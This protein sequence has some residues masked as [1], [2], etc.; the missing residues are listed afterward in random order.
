[1]KLKSM[2]LG[3]ALTTSLFLGGC[4]MYTVDALG[5]LDLG[6]SGMHQGIH[7]YQNVLSENQLDSNKVKIDYEPTDD[8]LLYREF[9]M[10]YPNTFEYTMRNVD[11]NISIRISMPQS[12]SL[13]VMESLI[14]N[15]LFD[16]MEDTSAET[17]EVMEAMRKLNDGE[18]IT[19][20][21]T[22]YAVKFKL[23]YKDG[24]YKVIYEVDGEELI[25]L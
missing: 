25:G 19:I 14:R 5:A 1:M 20:Q 2:M 13:N 16:P 11:H 22:E 21:P 17:T 7:A 12:V 4:S 6:I 10:N 15:M 8:S 9:S 24:Y 18:A 3:A 23:S